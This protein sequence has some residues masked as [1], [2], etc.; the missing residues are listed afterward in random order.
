MS[1][2]QPNESQAPDFLPIA[3]HGMLCL[4][5]VESKSHSLINSYLTP[6]HHRTQQAVQNLSFCQKS[7]LNIGILIVHIH[8]S[9]VGI[10]P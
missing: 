7:L 9:H 3:N 2:P 6:S 5:S 1:P 4:V 10:K 8:L